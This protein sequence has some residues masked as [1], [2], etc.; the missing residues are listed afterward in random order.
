MKNETLEKEATMNELD[1]RG[2]ILPEMIDTAD[3][4]CADDACDSTQ[5]SNN[6]ITEGEDM[7]LHEYN[8]IN[9][10]NQQIRKIATGKKCIATASAKLKAIYGS[11]ATFLRLEYNGTRA[12]A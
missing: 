10:E 11:K 2:Y 8:V 5:Q 3:W 7:T 6:T 12:T 4:P 9:T 1:D